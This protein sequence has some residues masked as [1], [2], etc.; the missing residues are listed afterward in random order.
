M[1]KRTN[2]EFQKLLSLAIEGK[3]ED[4]MND[5]CEKYIYPECDANFPNI[6]EAADAGFERAYEQLAIAYLDGNGC[7][8]NPEQ[9][10]HYLEKSLKAGEYGAYRLGNCY[11]LGI[12]VKQDFHKAWK[13]YEMASKMWDDGD[14]PSTSELMLKDLQWLETYNDEQ[15][16][17][18]LEYAL[19]KN[20]SPEAYAMISD[21]YKQGS[22]KYWFCIRKAAEGDELVWAKICLA[23]K[24]LE[25]KSDDIKKQKAIDLLKKVIWG[26]N[27]AEDYEIK[28]CVTILFKIVINFEIKQ[29]IAITAYRD[30]D[31]G[32]EFLLKLCDGNESKL[33]ILLGD[34]EETYE[35][36]Y[37][38]EGMFRCSC[39]KKMCYIDEQGDDFEGDCCMECYYSGKVSEP[40][41]L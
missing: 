19:K 14:G 26:N 8:V 37:I 33:E 2:E 6:K 22:E 41:Y 5:F 32:L 21:F 11:R 30:L 7:K 3:L 12:G 25:D 9:G 27:E 35:V 40:K 36:D 15:L 13:Y 38:P 20:G 17:P 16:I 1:S 4:D 23:E 39:C 29:K 18:W 31:N 10:I 34:T 24:L 28:Q